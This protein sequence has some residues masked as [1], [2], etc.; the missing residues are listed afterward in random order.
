MNYAATGRLAL[1]S[2]LFLVTQQALLQAYPGWRTGLDFYLVWLLIVSASRGFSTGLVLGLIG[3]LV[4]DA[5][6]N[7]GL[8]HTAF[9]V[10]PVVIGAFLSSHLV[11]EYNLLAGLTVLGLLLL[12]LLLLATVAVTAGWVPGWNC[13]LQLNY[14]P[15]LV[16]TLVVFVFWKRLAVLMPPLRM[17]PGGY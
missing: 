7:F 1:V 2:A 4:M 8:F 15:L 16:L 5:P 13:L 17:V 3:G 12:K 11:M 6:S 9:Y 10:L 14:L